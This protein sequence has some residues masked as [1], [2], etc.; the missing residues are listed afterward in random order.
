LIVVLYH[1]G[2]AFL[3]A[4]LGVMIF[5]VI[6]GFLITWLLLEE[7]DNTSRISLRHFYFRRTFRISRR[8]MFFGR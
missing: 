4:G 5:F 6:S 1:F 8:F 3:P 2:F 7:Y